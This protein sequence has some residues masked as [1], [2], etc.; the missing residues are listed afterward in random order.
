MIHIK[1]PGR[2]CLFGEH[3]DYLLYPVI[4]MAIN[5]YIYLKAERISS[6]KLLIELPDINDKIEIELNDKELEY[7]SKRDY[8]R[9]AYNQLLRKGIKF[10]RGFKVEITGDIPINAGVASSSALII[11]WLYFLNLI[12]E[13]NL[14]PFQLA[15]EG[16]NTEVKEFNEAGGMMDHFTSIYGNIVYLEPE[17][18][19]PKFINKRCQLEGFVLGNSLEEK[20]TVEDLFK[21]KRLAIKSFEVLKEIMPSFNQ[22]TTSIE[23]LNQYLPNLKNDYQEKII[24]NL[25]N[26]DLTIKAKSLIFNTRHSKN[27]YQELGTLLNLQHQQLKN[28]IKISTKKIDKMISNCLEKGALGAKIN[29]SGFGGTMFSLFPKNQELLIKAIE[30]AGGEAFTITTSSGV[31]TY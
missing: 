1:S 20:D 16:Y 19:V 15:M 13:D 21:V 14:D 17:T 11:A 10:K 25:T 6:K 30:N 22:Y 2:I 28:N 8:L 31:E 3:Q 24:G 23:E 18:P 9:S 4:S 12:C 29:G 7:Y 27:F 26:R 5:K